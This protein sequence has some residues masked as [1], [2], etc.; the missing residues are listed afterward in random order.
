MHVIFGFCLWFSFSFVFFFLLSAHHAKQYLSGNYIHIKL[1]RE[2]RHLKLVP[3]SVPFPFL[4]V[5]TLS[6]C[7]VWLNP[8]GSWR[9]PH[10]SVSKLTLPWHFHP[11]LTAVLCSPGRYLQLGAKDNITEIFLK[12]I[13]LS[14]VAPASLLHGTALGA[15]SLL[16]M[17]QVFLLLALAAFGLQPFCTFSFKQLS[18]LAFFCHEH[19]S[20]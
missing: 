1:I 4:S 9:I 14:G 8:A 10:S 11:L 13:D 17:F 18:K 6:G 19:R 2:S 20:L 3:Y 7:Q 5:F 12:K 15:A 16:Q